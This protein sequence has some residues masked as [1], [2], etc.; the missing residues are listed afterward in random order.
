MK[1]HW[2]KINVALFLIGLFLAGLVGT[3]TSMTFL[4]PAYAALGISGVFAIGLLF[5]ESTFQLPK[6]SMLAVFALLLYVFFRAIDSPVLYFAREDVALAVA[7]FLA[8]TGFLVACD[9]IKRRR[10]VVMTLAFLVVANAVFAVL[11]KSF[12]AG[13]WLLPGYERTSGTEVGGLFNQADHYAA[14]L[15]ATVPIWLGMTVFSRDGNVLRKVYGCLAFIASAGMA[16]ANSA[17]G[18]LVFSAG[19][20]SFLLLSA[21]LFWNRF[22]PSVRSKAKLLLAVVILFATALMMIF[23][24]PLS[25]ALSRD[26]L[27]EEG[28][29][30]LPLM[31]NAGA[32]QM[33]ESPITGTG[34]RSSY[35][36]GRA[37]R[38]AELA[39]EV[40]EP[41]FVH[42]EFLQVLADYGII[43]LLLVMVLL[44]LHFKSG[45]GFILAYRKFKPASGEMIQRSNHLAL[46]IGAFS[47][48]AA[49]LAAS[50]VDF[51]LHLP[52]FASLFAIL[53]AVLAAP[54]PMAT[55]TSAEESKS[56]FPGGVPLFATRVTAFSCGLLITAFGMRY[57]R[58]EYH[59]EQARIAFEENRID[60]KLMRHLQ[61]ARK[62]DPL[63]PFVLSLSAHAQVQAITPEMSSPA[64]KQALE[65]AEEYF[66]Q[67]Q[68]CYPQDVFAA[69]GHSAVLDELG[70]GDDAYRRIKSAREWAPLYGILIQAQGEHHLRRGDIVDA[71][72]AFREAL[73]AAAYPD[74]E[75][76]IQGLKTIAEWK[77]IA[78]QNGIRW[79]PEQDLEGG[80]DQRL[81]REVRV[82]ERILAGQASEGIPEPTDWTEKE[83]SDKTTKTAN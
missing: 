67:A 33:M 61:T 25:G 42:N 28:D 75:G 68:V 44:G 65:Q 15:G 74:S 20:A 50:M 83:P 16:L 11:Q 7:S 63:N 45:L 39:A 32:R 34:S 14:F 48:I 82:Q 55:A 51:P 79:V 49:I 38:P 3:S 27:T 54:D 5:R 35:I 21:L 53:L 52:A 1:A 78:S 40:G 36:Y 30:G 56:Y 22:K 19:V 12:G 80:G 62:L 23:S 37:F 70:R 31:W 76:A 47:A 64:R 59:Y 13:I 29:T 81:L 46:A 26:L 18:W 17:V 66:A 72:S 73:A 69:V 77:F 2:S 60:F 8:Y 6:W 4:W 57:M 10:A 9:S 41:E 43:G 24:G 58:S 71:E